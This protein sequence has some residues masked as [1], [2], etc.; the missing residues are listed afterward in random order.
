VNSFR[1]FFRK[2]KL[3]MESPDGAERILVPLE[4]GLFRIGEE[5]T[6]ETLRFDEVIGG[7]AQRANLSGAEFYRFFTP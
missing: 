4:P 1:V 5:R 3:W 2:G 7:W 6:P